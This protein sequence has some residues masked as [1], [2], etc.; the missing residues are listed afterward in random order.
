M[1]RPLSF[2][3]TIEILEDE[4]ICAHILVCRW[5][6]VLGFHNLDV[7]KLW[8]IAKNKMIGTPMIS[9]FLPHMPSQ[10]LHGRVLVPCYR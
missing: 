5:Y 3:I 9:L 2:N 1:Q 4:Y 6:W 8:N 7:G 10:L